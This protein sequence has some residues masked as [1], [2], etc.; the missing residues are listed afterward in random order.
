MV[1][2]IIK[3]LKYSKRIQA[4]D[5]FFTFSPNLGCNVADSEDAKKYV[6]ALLSLPGV[7]LSSGSPEP[8]KPKEEPKPQPKPVSPS[9]PQPAAVV[10]E[11]AQPKEEDKVE[12]KEEEKS[13]EP[14]NEVKKNN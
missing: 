4:L 11:K 12:I 9:G 1:K 6:D 10:E 7:E 13:P 14:S 3:G 5:K 2:L 8:S